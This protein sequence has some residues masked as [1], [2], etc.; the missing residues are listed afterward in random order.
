[1][2]PAFAGN[3]T[4]FS[5]FG[6][7]GLIAF[8]VLV[9]FASG[10]IIAFRRQNP[11]MLGIFAFVI[12]Y[13]SYYMFLMRFV[14]SWYTVPLAAAT[15][16]GSA[17]GLNSIL[18]GSVLCR[19]RMPLAYALALLYVGSFIAVTLLTFRGERNVQRYVEN[20]NRK[21]I[22]LYFAKV[23]TPQQTIGLEPLG[24]V[25]YYS[26]RRIYDYPGLCNREVVRY[27]REHPQNRNLTDMLGFFRPDFIVLR[28]YEYKSALAKGHEWLKTDYTLIR[29][30]RVPPNEFGNSCFPT[31]T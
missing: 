11:A 6:D 15:I 24:Y 22:G 17:I 27:I 13:A 23:S 12:V 8:L 25:G 28:P 1:L 10:L 14:F 21:Q 19:L 30:F 26:R 16:L 29:D 7:H 20:G 18:A 31:V 9:F 4:G 2:G 3:G 5:F